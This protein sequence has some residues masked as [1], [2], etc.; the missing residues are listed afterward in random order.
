MEENGK[1]VE[2]LA[3]EARV[4]VVPSA[5]C[6][7]CSAAEACGAFGSKTKVVLAK[8]PIGAKIGDLVKLET[9]EKNRLTSISLVFGLPIVLLLIGIILGEIISGDK[10]AAFLGGIGLVI[11]FIIAKIIDRWVGKKATF[12]PT[13][14]EKI[15]EPPQRENC[16]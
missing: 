1:V 3:S 10:L 14:I 4:E 6:G 15:S 13:I 9:K 11:A 2:V 7:H 12:L 5:I 16:P 8:N